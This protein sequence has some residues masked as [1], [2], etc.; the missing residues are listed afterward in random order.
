MD[1]IPN[2]IS[3]HPHDQKKLFTIDPKFGFRPILG[4]GR[5][6]EYG[7]KIN[8]YSIEKRQNTERLLFIGDSVTY[9]GKIIDALRRLFGEENFEYWNAGVESFNTVQEVNFYREYN[10]AISPDHVILT[11]HLNDF[12]TTPIS[13]YHGDKIVVYGPNTSLEDIN[14]WLFQHIHIYRLF[15]WLK[16][17]IT[18]PGRKAI[19]Q[20][21]QDSL[22]EMKTILA[23]N[24]TDFTVL[25]FPYLKPYEEWKPDEKESRHRIIG[26]LKELEIAYFDLFD[27]LTEAIH[28]GVNIQEEEGDSFH[29]SEEISI[30][31]AKY[32]YEKHIF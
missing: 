12:E 14:P 20:E 7:T 8:T 1:W 15:L 24:D 19:S 18:D 11:F 13:F 5:Y 3:N 26:I 32:L 21:V 31:F 6:S 23:T 28:N 29:P 25:I 22:M 4:T 17:A 27:I 9:R 16:I 30:L 2:H 10:M